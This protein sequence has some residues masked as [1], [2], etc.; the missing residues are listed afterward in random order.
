MRVLH[1][2]FHRGWGGQPS[3]ILMG[4]REHSRRGHV[5]AIA[6]PGDGELARR[7]REAGLTVFGGFGFHK[8]RRIFSF[9]RDV[10]L[11]QSAVR[12]FRP[13]ILHSHGSQDTW[14]AAISNRLSRR[15]RAAAPEG[16]DPRTGPSA[17]GKQVRAQQPA[18]AA[19]FPMR[20][21]HLMTRHNSKHVADHAANR[22]LYGHALD[23]LVVVSGGVLERYERFF[24]RGVLD[25]STVPVIPSSID[26]ARYNGPLDAGRLRRELGI[27]PGAPVIGAVGRLVRDK[28]Q[29]VLIR[30]MRTVLDAKPG[31][32]LALVGTG[33]QDAAHR[34][35]TAQLGLQKHVHFL[36]FRNDVPDLTAGFD[37]AVL[38][39]VDCDASPAAV[40][41][42]MY[43]RRPVVVTD[44]GGLREMV[45]DGVT[46]RVVPPGDPDALARAILALL[47][48]PT[49]SAAMAQR[50]REVVR[51]RYSLASLADAY[52]KVYAEML[53]SSA[54]RR[55]RS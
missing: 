33:T 50:A 36:G 6:T 8:L 16:R 47:D 46:G 25:P 1:L 30:A 15:P 12:E 10:A 38:A 39:S 5:V 11:L 21:P 20:V 3:R 32:Q 51:T 54:A 43:L 17:R 7:A 19:T 14:T 40:K 44:I 2:D 48:D 41:E 55:N 52:E 31:V 24:R 35:L 45:E 23:R 37:M 42:A 18:D 34:V 9:A 26:F 29:H 13:D 49:S 22:W 53:G 4:S 28:G 27:E